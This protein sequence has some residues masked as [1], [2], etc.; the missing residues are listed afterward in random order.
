MKRVIVLLLDSLGV[1]SGH[2]TEDAGAHTLGHVYAHYLQEKRLALPNLTS[3]GLLSLLGYPMLQN[4]SVGKAFPLNPNKDTPSG[5]WEIMGYA[6]PHVWRTFL[7]NFPEELLSCIKCHV[8][9]DGVLGNRHASGPDIV[10]ALG[11]QHCQTGWPIVYTSSDSV[12]QIAAHESTFGLQR[13]YNLCEN[14]FEWAKKNDVC[15]V[16]ARP[17]V[18][19]ENSYQRTYNRRDWTIPPHTTVIDTLAEYGG[20]CIAIGKIADIFAHRNIHVTH[21]THGLVDTMSV[22]HD[23]IHTPFN[24][25]T[26]IFSN[27]N[28]FDT[29]YGH[30]RDVVGYGEA[31][32]LFDQWLGTLSLQPHDVMII[33]ADHGCDP[34]WHGTN[35]TREAIPIVLIGQTPVTIG[36]R[37]TFA[38]IGASILDYFNMP[39]TFGTSWWS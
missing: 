10:N 19:Q 25:P 33:T 2:L 1:G 11:H 7:Q 30:R 4:T 16:I 14:V 13:L 37:H 21:R 32:A 39:I 27:F 12:I 28:E 8:P 17:F 22:T 29:L 23:V 6:V 36:V 3:Y 15:R 26:L 31:L 24:Q 5:H 34:T 18:T 9:C 35:H 38:D 20:Q